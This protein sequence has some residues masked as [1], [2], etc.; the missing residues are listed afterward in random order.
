MF[1]FFS[2]I[3][4]V[5]FVWS[6]S[7]YSLILFC[8]EIF[9]CFVHWFTFAGSPFIAGLGFKFFDLVLMF[10]FDSVNE[11]MLSPETTF[12]IEKAVDSFQYNMLI[13]NNLAVDIS[14]CQDFFSNLSVL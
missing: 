1:R 5:N 7:F 6:L 2:L 11:M 14:S 12:C 8:C 13:C 9:C 4:E 10:L 3:F